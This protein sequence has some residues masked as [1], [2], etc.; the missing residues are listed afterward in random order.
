MDH[1]QTP[2]LS[3]FDGAH[4]VTLTNL[5]LTS[6]TEVA[7]VHCCLPSQPCS[8]TGKPAAHTLSADAAPWF[9]IRP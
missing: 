6:L 3:L 2:A 9:H 8:R 7:P 5:A 4:V 1:V